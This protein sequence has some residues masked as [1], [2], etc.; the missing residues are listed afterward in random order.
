M[1]HHY[2][3]AVPNLHRH[4]LRQIFWLATEQVYSSPSALGM[5]KESVLM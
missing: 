2:L 5:V 1:V 3:L 4:F